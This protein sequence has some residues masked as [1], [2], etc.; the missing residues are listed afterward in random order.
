M[1]IRDRYISRTIFSFRYTVIFRRFGSLWCGASLTAIIYFAVFKGLKS[2]LA[3][4]AFVGMVDRHLLLS[5]FICW[6]ACSVLLFFI[7]RFKIN[8]LRITILSG[9]FALALAF[10]GNDLVNFIGVPV[11]GFDAFSIAKHSGDP[12]M[13]MG[14]LSENVP[15]N[16]LILLAAG[17]MM[18]LTLWTSKKAMHVSETELSLS[19]AQEDE[20]PEQYGSSVMSRTIVRAAPVSYTHLHRQT[21]HDVL[22]DTQ[23]RLHDAGRR[24]CRNRADQGIGGRRRGRGCHDDVH[25]LSLIHIL[26]GFSSRRG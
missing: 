25:A 14:A 10:A 22:R 3:D 6:V 8:I 26:Y 19:A 23:R 21:A 20:G 17:A 24:A 12:Q 5:L 11:A 2:L 13:M 15:A 1:C 9:T 7:Q 16:F 4:N 18:I